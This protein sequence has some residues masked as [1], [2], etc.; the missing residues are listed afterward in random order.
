MRDCESGI[1]AAVLNVLTPTQTLTAHNARKHTFTH[2]QH[3]RFEA[4]MEEDAHITQASVCYSVLP[5]KKHLW[6]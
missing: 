3:P 2:R 6:T 4:E 5:K 1:L